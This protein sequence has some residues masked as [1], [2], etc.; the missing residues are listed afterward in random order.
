MAGRYARR[1]RTVSE[2]A[3]RIATLL[4]GLDD[5]PY[6]EVALGATLGRVLAVDLASP[7]DL[8]VFRNSQ[9]DGFAVRAESV[10]SVPARLPIQSTVAAGDPG[11]D[12][13]AA[14][15]AVRIM[16][17]AP[18]PPGAD[19]V[20]PVED[21]SVV[22]EI[23]TVERGRAVGEY[24]REPGVDVRR[25]ALLVPAGVR[26]QPRHIAAIAAVG[27]GTVPIRR[28]PRAAVIT[29][30]SELVAAGTPLG[31]GQIYNSNGITVA[32]CLSANGADVVSVAHSSDA[33]DEFRAVLAAATAIADLVVTSG[34]VSMGDF[35]VVRAVLEPLG[36]E[37]GRVAMQPGGPQGSTIVDGV[38]VLSFPGNPVSTLISFEVFLR[39][40]LCRAAGLPVPEC[41]ELRL[42]RPVRSIAGKRQFLRGRR[43]GDDVDVVSGPGS[44]LV[45]GMAAADVL[46]DLPAD[47]VA[48]D[49]GTTVE[50]VAL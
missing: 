3:K 26:L 40:V 31:P 24:V 8:P 49:A 35:E 11:T 18:M 7:L 43:I 38:P 12:P 6:E 21:T 29:T 45:A 39:P 1:V 32:S 5:L 46:I 27:L 2:H 23:V 48:L 33:A 20:I 47:A 19:C 36:G 9:M 14:G 37:F 44:H 22:D 41:F 30:G 15:H 50:V 10:A 34:G 4:A 28:R 17:G 13:L 16:T 42:T 25:G